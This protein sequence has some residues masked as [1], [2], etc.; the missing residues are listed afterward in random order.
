MQTINIY[1]GKNAES[2]LEKRK[3]LHFEVC[4]DSATST[5]LQKF[6]DLQMN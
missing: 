6:T 5:Y 2:G 4:F 3:N 1:L